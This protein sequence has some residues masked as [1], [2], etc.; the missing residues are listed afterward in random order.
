M[1]A[2]STS[3]TAYGAARVVRLGAALVL[4]VSR[5]GAR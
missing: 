2:I 4:G 3:V 5:P 1:R